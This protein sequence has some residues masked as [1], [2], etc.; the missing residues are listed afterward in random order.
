[1]GNKRCPRKVADLPSLGFK[2]LAWHIVHALS[3]EAF[4]L[5]T[6]RELG[7]A[8]VGAAAI[9][10]S[11]TVERGAHRLALR[12]LLAQPLDQTNTTTNW[13]HMLNI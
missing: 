11:H 9:Q 3:A 7:D 4:T 12:R 2:G 5:A 13:Q 8:H 6:Q 10:H 1:M